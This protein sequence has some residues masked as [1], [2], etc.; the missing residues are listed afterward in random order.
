MPDFEKIVQSC[1][2]ERHFLV[3]IRLIW[4]IMSDI[5]LQLSKILR[6]L[7]NFQEFQVKIV[8]NT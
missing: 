4:I 1:P 6:L 8:Q 5:G 7:D 2:K 3:Y